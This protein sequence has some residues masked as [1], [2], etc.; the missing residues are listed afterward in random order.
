MD[1]GVPQD[2]RRWPPDDDDH[3]FSYL[4]NLQI[5]KMTKNYKL[6]FGYGEFPQKWAKFA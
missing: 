5:N 1:K 4:K 2:N 6:Y 3:F